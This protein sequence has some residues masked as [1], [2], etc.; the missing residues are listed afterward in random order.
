MSVAGDAEGTEG[1]AGGIQEVVLEAAAVPGVE[2]MA[3]DSSTTALYR[4]HVTAAL[5]EVVTIDV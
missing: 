1:T 4:A 5:R 2:L 3:D